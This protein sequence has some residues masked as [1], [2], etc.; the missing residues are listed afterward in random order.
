MGESPGWTSHWTREGRSFDPVHD[1]R[2]GEYGEEGD[3]EGEERRHAET[4][5]ESYKYFLTFV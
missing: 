4:G 5:V 2:Y 1:L 3:E